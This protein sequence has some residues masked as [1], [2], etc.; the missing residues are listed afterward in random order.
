M[1]PIAEATA[2]ITGKSCSRKYIALGRIVNAWPE[3]VGA[4]LAGKAQPVKI[5]Y[6]KQKVAKTPVAVLEIAVSSADATLLHYQKDLILERINRIF[7]EGWVTAIRFVPVAANTGKKT[8]LKPKKSL[9]EQEKT[10]LSGI[11]D[12]V[13]DPDVKNSLAA[14][15]QA[16][17]TDKPMDQVTWQK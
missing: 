16:V 17:M 13:E 1:R 5:N 12:S 10:Y 2:R 14:L 8:R 3:I 9:T 6:I 15:G 7:G 11:L 4:D